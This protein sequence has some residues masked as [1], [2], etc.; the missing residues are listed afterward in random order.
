MPVAIFDIDGTLTDSVRQ[1]QTA[2][3]QALRAFDFPAL[4]TDWA[5]YRHHSD[6]AIF[7]EAWED[8]GWGSLPD[9]PALE[10]SYAIAYDEAVRH[11]PVDEIAG[12]SAFIAHLKASGWGVAFA[13][14]SLRHGA[15]HKLSVLGIDG[16]GEALVT[17]SEARTREQI[18]S[19]A[20]TLVR[21]DGETPRV[22]SFGDGLW[23]LKTAQNLGFEFFGIGSGSKAEAL[24]ARGATVHSNFRGLGRS[25][26]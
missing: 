11:L 26:A 20:V 15:L 10:Q 8:A 23:D 6:S 16:N 13:T 19:E 5:S 18:V 14:G 2:F 24:K 7:E 12:A 4:C 3:E 25:F 9:H 17:A 1:H 22:V 21:S